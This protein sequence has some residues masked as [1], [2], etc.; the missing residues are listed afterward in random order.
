MWGT[1]GYW[2]SGSCCGVEQCDHDGKLHEQGKLCLTRA[3][4][5]V[6]ARTRR[7]EYADR[8][9][10]ASRFLGPPVSRPKFSVALGSTVLQI[11]LFPRS[12]S[13]RSVKR[14]S[15]LQL[16]YKLSHIPKAT[17]L[18]RSDLDSKEESQM[19]VPIVPME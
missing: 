6:K 19:A 13:W 14:E 16:R 3:K 12:R 8:K 9:R 11:S 10:D 17:S 18:V 5:K 1:W 15:D 4:D 2:G 7:A